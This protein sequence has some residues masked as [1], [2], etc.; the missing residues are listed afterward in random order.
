MDT[1]VGFVNAVSAN[2]LKLRRRRGL[3]P[4]EAQIFDTGR[5]AFRPRHVVRRC[6]PEPRLRGVG[7]TC[8]LC[9]GAATSVRLVPTRQWV[10][11]VP[12]RLRPYLHHDARVAGAVLQ[13]FLRAIRTTLRRTSPGAPTDAQLGAV[14][15]STAS[16]RP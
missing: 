13:I 12:K 6:S 14:A 8:L 15:S 4:D 5:H 10:L 2:V 3:T 16:V 11:S 9:A 7:A 1:A